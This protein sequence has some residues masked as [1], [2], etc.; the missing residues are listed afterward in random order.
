MS[1]PVTSSQ[2]SKRWAASS[3]CS[4]IAFSEVAD[5]TRATS[6]LLSMQTGQNCIASDNSLPQLGQ[7]RWGS[8]LMA[9]SALQPQPES[10]ATRL[11]RAWQ[12]VV[13]FHKLVH[14]TISAASSDR[15]EKTR[16]TGTSDGDT[17]STRIQ[18]ILGRQKAQ[19]D[20]FLVVSQFLGISEKDVSPY[21]LTRYLLV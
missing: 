18:K 14:F 9:L 4:L 20:S 13:L 16:F 1:E 12:T 19:P 6:A 17:Y 7:V 10:K 21:A 11:R 15:N 3:G 2:C 8:A 5:S